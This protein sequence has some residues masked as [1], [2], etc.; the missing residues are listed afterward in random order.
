M[1]AASPLEP[2]WVRRRLRVPR[3][4]GAVL[5]IPPV[6]DMPAVVSNNRELIASWNVDCLGKSLSELRQLARQEALI[7]A[8]QYTDWLDAANESNGDSCGTRGSRVSPAT[9]NAREPRAPQIKINQPLIVSGHQ[10]EL[11]HP[12]VWAKN[13]ALDQLAHETGGIGLNLIVDS[14][15]LAS[16]RIAAPVGSKARP[17]LEHIPFDVDAGPHERNRPSEELAIRDKSLFGSFAERVSH[18]LACWPVDPLVRSIWPAAVAMLSCDTAR[19]PD[20]LT[21][22]RRQAERDAGLNTLELPLSRLSQTEAFAWFVCHL[23]SDVRRLHVTYNA[24]VEQ[25]RRVNQVR[26]ASHPLP[27]LAVAGIGSVSSDTSDAW[28]EVPFWIWRTGDSERGRLFVRQTASHVI[29]SNGKDELGSLPLSAT[30]DPT[31]SV[32]QLRNLMSNGFKIR[33]RALTTTMFARVFLGDAFL[34][35]LGGAKYDEMTDRLIARLFGVVPPAYLTLTATAHLPITAWDTTPLDVAQLR[36]RLSD[37]DHNVEQYV[38][39]SDWPPA[40]RA[41]AESLLAEKLQLVTEQIEQDALSATHPHRRM[42]A[43]NFQ[44]C[45]RLRAINQRLAQLA[46][47]THHQ[48]ATNLQAAQAHLSANEILRSREF[49][50]CLFPADVLI[51][52]L[53]RRPGFPA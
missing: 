7:A 28:F 30:G 31:I 40:N 20:A 15:T 13:F 4:H 47:A 10:P 35:G 41:E 43:D 51:P 1:L 6:R 48:L 38:S 52:L 3:E 17:T 44:R 21:A 29:L 50:F 42:K 26:S 14:D 45:R 27:N 37:F 49:S 24:V 12:G 34:H 25:Y 18:A 2:V 9:I 5:A 19:L 23:L 32:A 46:E 33:T 16:T 39:A 8:R 11:F 36:H 53:T 22:A